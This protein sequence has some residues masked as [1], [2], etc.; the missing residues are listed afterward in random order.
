MWQSRTYLRVASTPL[1]SGREKS[2]TAT[3]GFVSSA[4]WDRLLPEGS[5]QFAPP[6]NPDLVEFNYPIRAIPD[7]G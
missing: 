7:V 4:F 3:L 6:T 1:T 2:I 5:P